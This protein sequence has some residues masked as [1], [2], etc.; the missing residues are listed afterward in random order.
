MHAGITKTI[1]YEGQQNAKDA[2]WLQSSPNTQ[3]RQKSN[4]EAQGLQEVLRLQPPLLMCIGC[5]VCCRGGGLSGYWQR[6]RRSNTA[7][8][9]H[10]RRSDSL[11][12]QLLES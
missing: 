2:P 11:A 1:G 8:V 12:V 7:Y 9:A 4:L 5:G 3:V 10:G 6:G